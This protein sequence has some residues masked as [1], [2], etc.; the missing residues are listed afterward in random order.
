MNKFIVFLIVMQMFII[1]MYGLLLL[2]GYAI[3]SI[4]NENSAS[5]NLSAYL[6]GSNSVWP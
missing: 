1:S 4:I 5:K 3:S 6:V 2:R